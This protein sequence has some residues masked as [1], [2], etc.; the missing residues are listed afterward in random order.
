MPRHQWPENR[1]SV[2]QKLLVQLTRILSVLTVFTE[3][4]SFALNIVFFAEHLNQHGLN[5]IKE[6]TDGTSLFLI[7]AVAIPVSFG[8][9]G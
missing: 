7:G 9:L 3:Q 4:T 1:N 5:L 6:S 8:V 2:T